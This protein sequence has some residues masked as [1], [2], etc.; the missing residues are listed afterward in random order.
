[1]K[2]KQYLALLYLVMV[3]AVLPLSQVSAQTLRME[4]NFWG[5]KLYADDQLKSPGEMLEIMKSDPEAYQEFKKAKGNLAGAT[6][7]GFIGGA[8][9]GWPIGTSVGGGD[10]QWGLAGGGA[11]LILLSI[12]LSSG[13]NKHAER[14]IELYNS[15]G[16]T[17]R[18]ISI[19]VL[20]YGTGA[21]LVIRF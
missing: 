18:R 5:T 19:G 1:M 2:I 8:L 3:I 15:E 7:L 11:A 14:A 4:K 6:V 17:S 10:P 21:K 9:I 12:P 16:P 20:P 13:F